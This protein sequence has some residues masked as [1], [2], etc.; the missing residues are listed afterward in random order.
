M[1][2]ELPPMPG[3]AKQVSSAQLPG[4][5]PSVKDIGG[6]FPMHIELD[7]VKV[8][9]AI[10]DAIAFAGEILA[11]AECHLRYRRG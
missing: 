3:S 9:M 11:V 5:V 8:E 2:D 6:D 10:V 1:N 7:G 4:V